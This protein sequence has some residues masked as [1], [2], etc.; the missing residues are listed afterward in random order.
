[1]RAVDIGA[2]QSQVQVS[3][4]KKQMDAQSQAASKLFEGLDKTEAVIQQA[5]ESGKG[6]NID[7]RV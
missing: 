1:M 4:L 6:Q 5:A 2:V 3:M 7:V